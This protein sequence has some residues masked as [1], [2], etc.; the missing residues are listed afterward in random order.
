MTASNPEERRL[1]R[2][3][4]ERGR[5]L[6]E[7]DMAVDR[8]RVRQVRAREEGRDRDAEIEADVIN[9]CLAERLAVTGR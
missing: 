5:K 7:I 1:A 3:A 4:A 6:M 2:L 8:A 9:R